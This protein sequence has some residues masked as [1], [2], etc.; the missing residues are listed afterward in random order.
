MLLHLGVTCVSFCLH[1]FFAAIL[2]HRRYSCIV[3]VFATLISASQV[4]LVSVCSST[5]SFG[6][7]LLRDTVACHVQL[8]SPHCSQH[9]GSV[10][11]HIDMLFI[12]KMRGVRFNLPGHELMRTTFRVSIGNYKWPSSSHFFV[13]RQ[14]LIS[15]PF[16][17]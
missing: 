15:C 3:S 5:A 4:I 14:S 9:H 16:V 8:G 17:A 6:H 2:M 7:V 1:I 11:F 12:I 10:L 13:L